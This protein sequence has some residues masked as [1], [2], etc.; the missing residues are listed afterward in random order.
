MPKAPRTSIVYPSHDAHDPW[1]SR[2][3][4]LDARFARDDL[5]LYD[6]PSAT[7]TIFE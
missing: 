4:M 2:C 7:N 3:A 5:V 6:S 1:P